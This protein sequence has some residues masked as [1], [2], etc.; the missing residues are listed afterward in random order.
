MYYSFHALFSKLSEDAASR[1]R[2]WITVWVIAGN[3]APLDKLGTG[4]TSS[5]IIVVETYS[6]CRNNHKINEITMNCNCI[7]DKR[8]IERH[9]TALK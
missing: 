5:E 3:V 8:S 9:M 2:I 1:S 6:N 4:E 7:M